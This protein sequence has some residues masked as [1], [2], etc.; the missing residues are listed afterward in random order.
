MGGE[1]AKERRSRHAGAGQVDV[2]HA[3]LKAEQ[4]TLIEIDEVAAD[5]P[6]LRA[7]GEMMQE[8]F[9]L[10]LVAALFEQAAERRFGEMHVSHGKSSLPCI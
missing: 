8:E 10:L 4:A 6:A 3:E 9:R 5:L 1:L 7:D 2:D